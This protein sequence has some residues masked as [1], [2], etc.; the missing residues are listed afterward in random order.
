MTDIV[1]LA[2][3]SSSAGAGLFRTPRPPPVTTTVAWYYQFKVIVQDRPVN[4]DNQFDE[5]KYE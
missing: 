2:E 4:Q 3:E 1:S 5:G